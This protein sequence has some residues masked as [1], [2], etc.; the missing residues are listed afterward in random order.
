MANPAVGQRIRQARK[1]MGLTQREFAE[2]LGIIK[3]S[4]ARYETGRLP[5]ADLLDKIARLAGVTTHWLLHGEPG[6]DRPTVASPDA[7]LS[8]SVRE[9][10]STLRNELLL[11]S[12]LHISRRNRYRQ[13]FIESAE[14]MRREIGEYRRLLQAEHRAERRK[15]DR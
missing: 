8:D 11:E 1:R 7:G 2:R 14:R 13:R 15:R 5:R 3:V 9:V 10:L 4:V 6:S 12:E